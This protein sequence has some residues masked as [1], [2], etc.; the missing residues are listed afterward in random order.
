[1]FLLP[2]SS[3]GRK[4][5]VAL[6]GLLLIGFLVGHLA[7]NLLI[8]LGPEPFNNYA[9]KLAGLRPGLFVVEF[10]LLAVFIGHIVV[11]MQLAAENRKA[12]G[13]SYGVPAKAGARSFS[14]RVMPYSGGLIFFFVVLHLLDFTFKLFGYPSTIEGFEGD[15]ELYGVVYNSF[16]NWVHSYLYVMA[17]ICLGFHLTHAI[18][19][20]LRSF[21]WYDHKLM[22]VFM[23]A[24]VIIGIVMAASYSAIPIAVLTR[25]IGP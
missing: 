7:G 3:I 5:F 25:V 17:M 12:R 10:G 16:S 14:N 8:F 19:S 18:Q 23:R 15:F 24:S 21:G 13:G 6:T 4:K 20:V 9:H 11:T 1:M 2:S 22:P